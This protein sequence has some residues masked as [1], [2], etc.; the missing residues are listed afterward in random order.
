[1][2]LLNIFWRRLRSLG[3]RRA[4]KQEIDEELRFHIEQR[5]AENIATGMSPEEAAREAKKRFGNLQTVR[6]ECREK[7]GASFGETLAQDVRFGLRMLRKNPGFTT[8]AVLTLALGIGATTAIFSVINGVLLEP[9]PYEQPGQLVHL[10]EMR[11]NGESGD[12]S[13]GAFMDWRE[14]STSFEG[15]SGMRGAAAN[16]TRT[17]QPERINGLRVSANFLSILREQP[18]IGRGFLPEEERLGGGDKVVVLAYGLWQRRFGGDTNLVGKSIWLDGESRTV[19]GVLPRNALA[20]ESEVDFLIPEGWQRHYG[21]NN[22]RV[23]GRLKPGVIV[24]QARAE[25]AAMKQ[26]MH[27]HYP[28]YKEKWSVT[29]VPMH[30]QVT[31]E[32]KPT[33]LILLGAVGCVLL[34]VCANLANLL[35][36]RAVARQREMAVRAALGASRWR[37]IRQVL[38][39]SV[40]LATLGGVLGVLVAYAGVNTLL[41]WN[42]GPV[43][44]LAEAHVDARMLG[45]A[46]FIAL[47]TGVC[48]GVLPALQMSG[49]RLEPVL[50]EGGRGV[51]AGSRGR[52]QS[53]LIIAEIGLALMLL[54]GAGLLVR[55]FTKLMRVSPGFVAEYALAMDLSMPNIKYP[56]PSAKTEFVQSVV[57]RISAVP[58]VETAGYAWNRPMQGLASDERAM[59]VVGRQDTP[60]QGYGVKYE[61]VAGDYF[62]AVG[63]PLLRGRTFGR[64][65][66]STNA[67]PVLVCSEALARKAFPNEDPVGKYVQF[68][69]DPKKFEIIGMVGDIKL[70]QLLDDRPDRIYFPH[71][72]GNGS[73]IVRTR[74]APASLAES[75]RKTVLEVDADQ[76]VSNIR[77]LEQDISRSV[78]PRRQTL[79]LLGLFA[80]IA[81]GLAALGL[82]GVLAH[83]VAL[84]RHEIG[85]RMAL[86]A[87][88]GNVVRLVLRHGL[89]LTLIGLAAGLAGAFALS[90]F[91]RN[92]L[93]EVGPTDPVIFAAV[94]ATLLLVALAA[95]WLP[96]RRASRVDPIE[97]LRCE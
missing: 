73:L 36:S 71:V 74:V 64:A 3:Q 87:E 18:E 53:G 94:S 38:T 93:Y 2:N 43:R 59:W 46:L 15:V 65:D 21:A 76:P 67:V 52:L 85:I 60:D 97:A 61:G 63:I 83:A 91:L 82:Y 77:T 84:R 92:Q 62:R 25:L 7:R 75:I 72:A 34:V 88:R 29:V 80:G 54:T 66:F 95:S 10:W 49:L 26:R 81:L 9:L 70:T 13:P 79:T 33:L 44:H 41:A 45:F 69:Q 40:L 58:R 32:V 5:T 6:E 78:A 90:R 28:K 14:Q 4:V 48:F 30:A 22:L 47:G 35:L 51:V 39:E 12:V 23:I 57:D 8:V 27:A 68:D 17:D 96:A 37:M 50:K 42:E 19:V 55:S 16:L 24:E 56:S 11:P 1:M 31:G 86:G 20:T 89:G